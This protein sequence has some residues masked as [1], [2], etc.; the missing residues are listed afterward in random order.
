MVKQQLYWKITA[1][2]QTYNSQHE[3]ILADLNLWQKHCPGL[4]CNHFKGGH[5]HVHVHMHL[6]IIVMY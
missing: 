6:A 2:E 5:S 1:H 4:I 3:T